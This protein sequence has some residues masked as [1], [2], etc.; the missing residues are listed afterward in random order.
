VERADFLPTDPMSLVEASLACPR[1]LHAVDWR[2]AGFG[3]APAVECRCRACGHVRT[4]ALS[5]H[6]LLRL[7]APEGEDGHQALTLPGLGVSMPYLFDL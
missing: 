5:A 2:A 1:C 4:V 3:T 7:T 6:Q